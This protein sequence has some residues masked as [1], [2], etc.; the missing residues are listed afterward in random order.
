MHRV[1][2]HRRVAP[3]SR[4]RLLVSSNAWS[5]LAPLAPMAELFMRQERRRAPTRIIWAEEASV[6]A[7]KIGRLEEM[8]LRDLWAHEATGFSRWLAE[9]LDV[10]SDVLG[11]AITDVELEKYGG[12]FPADLVG[13]D[14]S[15]AVV[16]IENQLEPTDHK[17]LGQ[18]LTHLRSFEAKTAVWITRQARSEHTN[19]INWLNEVTPDDTA[20]YLVRVT[21]YRIGDSPGAPQFTVIA[22]PSA[23][24]K[25]V[26]AEKHDLAERH[27]LRLKFWEDLLRLAHD[28]GAVTHA[29]VRPSKEHWLSA[30]AGRSG[31]AL[32]YLVAVAENRSGGELYIDTGERDANKAIFDALASQKGA[33]EQEFGGSLAWSRL[34]DKRASTVRFQ[35]Q[36][37]SLKD[38][39]GW[40]GLQRN[41]IGA[42]ERFA[43]ALQ[44]RILSL[45][46]S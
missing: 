18:L 14:S 11:T 3:R 41:M 20:F 44:P 13:S 8:P 34:D 1:W 43:A 36:G 33:I 27:V 45:P 28:M 7:T 21:A 40:P 19:V 39:E 25:A 35:V 42:M 22:G 15:G 16:I 23:E 24:S 32:S 30:G 37:G 5:F 6:C 10:L 4:S 2:L 46:K 31:L 29:A 12:D 38:L 26:G 17:H 9:N